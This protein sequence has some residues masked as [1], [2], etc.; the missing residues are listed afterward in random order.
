MTLEAVGIALLG[1]MKLA[2]KLV[3]IIVPLVTLFELLRHLPVFRRVGEGVDP[4]MRGIGLTREAALPLFTGIFLGIAYGA[5]ILIRVAQERRLPSRELFLMGLF[6]ATCHAVVEDTLIFVVIGG[7]G[8]VMLGV[9]LVMAVCLT[10][11]LARLWRAGRETP[12]A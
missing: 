6:L 2:G 7:N 5:G 12:G 3:L 8:T 1:A 4:L 9:R 10:A 11:L